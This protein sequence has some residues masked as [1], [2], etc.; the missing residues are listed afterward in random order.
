MR[1][2]TTF[3][4]NDMLVFDENRLAAIIRNN[5]ETCCSFAAIYRAM[6]EARR[7]RSK[8]A[9]QANSRFSSKDGRYY[10]RHRSARLRICSRL[11]R[12][13]IPQRHWTD[14][15]PEPGPPMP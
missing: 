4:E 10:R 13:T 8:I 11:C 1:S 3:D 5:V 2:F 14:F 7:S 6:P 15:S 9:R 12:E